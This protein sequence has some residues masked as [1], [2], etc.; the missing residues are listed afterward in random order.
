MLM[1]GTL[2]TPQ[3][4]EL[5]GVG[6][7]TILEA[8]GVNVTLNLTGVGENMMDH[9]LIVTDYVANDGVLT[10]GKLSAVKIKINEADWIF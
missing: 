2:K 4:L 1:A 5:S 10:L 7:P 8:A 6:N 9:L 3:V